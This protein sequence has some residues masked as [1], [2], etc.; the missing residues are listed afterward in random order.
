MKVL[1]L[2]TTRI[3]MNNMDTPLYNALKEYYNSGAVPFHMPGHKLGKAFPEDFLKRMA[4]LDV[5]EIPGTDNLRNPS[6]VI[7]KAQELSA[8]AFGSERTF[9]LVNGSTCGIYA[10]ISAVCKPGD[11]LIVARDCH[12]SV[13]YGMMMAGVKPVFIMPE[14]DS[15]FGINTAITPEKLGKTLLANKNAAGV[16]LTRP[17]Y[18]GICCDLEKI[19]ELVHSQGKILAVDEAHG[20]HLKFCKSLPVC[21]MDAGADICVQSAHKTLPALTQGAFLHVKSNMADLEKL[22]YYLSLYQT[23]SPS[24]LI[25]ASLDIAREI[26]QK[27]GSSLLEKLLDSI[28]K[29]KA[30]F[31]NEG[32]T[33]IDSKTIEE[34]QTDP[35]RIAINTEKLGITGF[36]ADKELRRKFNLQVEMSDLYNIV[37]ISTAADTEETI[38]YLF[39]C[40][41]RLANSNSGGEIASNRVNISLKNPVQQMD[42]YD[43]MQAKSR[44][45]GL[46][47]AAGRI[48]KGI[49]APYP[50]G[51]P[52]ICPGEVIYP[53]VISQIMHI[54]QAGGE[55]NGMNENLEINV[56]L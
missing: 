14:S 6:G 18:Y 53:D 51:I 25:M 8:K 33:F 52:V 26:M 19:A 11:T 50:P 29:N 15:R 49:V 30:D 48:S 12:K 36:G 45:I 47:K 20:P 1:G 27:E 41:E 46:K 31:S 42:Y 54:K 2:Y 44:W 40:L 4:S 24:Y 13:I 10:M 37:C 22:E 23:S 35:T 39:S 43:V 17:N 7:K 55:I 34:F 32:I 21:A 3:K 9:F 56:I 38:R 16:L 5:T 28:W